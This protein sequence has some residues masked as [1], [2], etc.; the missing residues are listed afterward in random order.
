[1][2]EMKAD[3]KACPIYLFLDV[4]G[5]VVDSL[6]ALID[7]VQNIGET[8]YGADVWTQSVVLR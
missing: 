1:M 5:D 3:E 8:Q 6:C 2:R 4:P 7:A